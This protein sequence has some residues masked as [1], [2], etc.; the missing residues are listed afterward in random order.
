MGCVEGFCFEG[1]RDE[2][3]VRDECCERRFVIVFYCDEGFWL[4]LL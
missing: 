3:R 2:G 1:G 4:F